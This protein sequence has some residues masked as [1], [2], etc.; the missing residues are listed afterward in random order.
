M[1]NNVTQDAQGEKL[2]TPADHVRILH[3]QPGLRGKAAMAEAAGRW[4]EKV[5]PLADLRDYA[6]AQR[7]RSDVYIS[8]NRFYGR[9]R[10]IVSL[11]ET[12]VLWADLDFYRTA[13]KGTKPHDVAFAALRRIDDEDMPLPSYVVHSGRGLLVSWLLDKPLP[14]QALPRWQACER[15]LINALRGFGADSNAADAARVFRLVGSVNSK[16]HEA[17]ECIWKSGVVHQFEELCESVL[18]YTRAEVASFRRRD[19]ARAGRRITAAL[20]GG[21][22]W[23]RRLTDLQRLRSVRFFGHLPE[24]ERDVWLFLASASLTW[25]CPPSQVR[26]EVLELAREALGTAWTEREILGQ[27]GTAVRRAEAAGRGERLCCKKMSTELLRVWPGPALSQ[28]PCWIAICS[29]SAPCSCISSLIISGPIPKAR[30]TRRTSP[31]MPDWSWKALACFFRRA[32]IASKP[33]IVA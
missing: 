7:G 17:V 13:W 29:S 1:H 28:N 33:L 15:R 8:Q 10:R 16:A 9:R 14:R 22:L 11:A 21:T 25:I 6:E 12:N 20:N 4:T 26:R 32:R 30:S 5:I 18:Q 3:G 31:L 23:E 19:L 24:G 27:M 2:D